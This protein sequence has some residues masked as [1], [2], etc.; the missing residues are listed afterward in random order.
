MRHAGVRLHAALPNWPVSNDWPT[1]IRISW[2][3]QSELKRMMTMNSMDAEQYCS[4]RRWGI[5]AAASAL[6]FVVYLMQYQISALA[7]LLSPE[8]GLTPI[9]LSNLM[10][11]PMLVAAVIGLPLGALA[12]RFGAKIVVGVCILVSLLGAMLRV[13]AEDYSTMLMACMLLG[14]APAALNANV[15][16]VFGVW[17][18]PKTNLAIGI[19]YACSGLGAS[20]AML[21]SANF[22]TLTEAFAFSVVLLVAALIAWW[23]IVR[24]A[25]P[26]VS[27]HIGEHTTIRS[28]SIAAKNWCVWCV[29]LITGF[30]LAA[31][32][33]YL[34]FLPQAVGALTS[35]QEANELAAFVAYG[36]IAGCALGPLVS[37]CFRKP[38]PFV[39]V[40][41]GV[42]SAIMI[43]SG[44]LISR[45][46]AVLFFLAG[47]LSSVTAPIVEAVPTSFVSLRG[48]IGS[49]GGIIGTVSLLMSY[50]LPLVI[51]VFAA[52][53][54]TKMIIFSGVCFACTMPF[55][56][57][58]PGLNRSSANE[59]SRSMKASNR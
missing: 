59:D 6:I 38:R 49:A 4:P 30:G 28:M 25:P 5:L 46:Q 23:S 3:E 8:L 9:E 7:L 31:K 14:F 20:A 10:F 13:F 35:I 2:D 33:A 44:L 55:L 18:G 12:D 52:G 22:A 27:A 36:G 48:S 54:M 40:V 50:V 15:M 51:T 43:A 42:G 41:A 21:T 53:S 29:A 34:S 58:L 11:V 45:P 19:Y 17:F 56:L 57:A 1:P 16:R 37:N 24:D 32:T 47:A 39:I 26:G